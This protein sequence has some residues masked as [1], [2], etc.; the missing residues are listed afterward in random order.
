VSNRFGCR[1]LCGLFL[2]SPAIFAQSAPLVQD[3]FVVPGNASNYGSTT[4]LNVGGPSASQ[5]LVQFDLTQLPAGT[6]ASGIAKATLVLFVNKLSAAGTVNF[7]VANGIWTESSANGASGTPVAAAAVASGVT[8]NNSSDYIAVDATAAVQAWLNGTTNSG[9]IITPNTGTGVNIFFDSKES[10]TTSHPAV[11]NVT[12][13]G[14]GGTTG[15]T[16]ATGPTGAGTAGATGQAGPTGATGP[17][18]T[19]GSSGATGT[20]G[21]T[22]AGSTGATGATGPT[23]TNG[24]NGAT[25]TTGPTGTNG[26]NGS[27]GSNGAT[28]PTGGFSGYTK[29]GTLTS[30]Q[31]L[32]TT[33]TGFYPVND[34]VTVTLPPATTAG[35]ALIF[36]DVTSI[37]SG[38]TI[39]A[40]SG[41][42]IINL[43]GGRNSSLTNAVETII[44]DGIH[45]W[46]VLNQ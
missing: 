8:I 13:V 7:S 1:F 26:S 29:L 23:G 42:T 46:F 17:T 44:S 4:T 45:H 21:A 32:S 18:G 27:A 15:A 14:S 3:S 9:F 28:G 19:N 34:G 41:D 11:L 16:G 31:T 10:T 24:S 20:T 36:V 12:L 22:G 25:G 40:G 37:S 33:S 5:A 6:T 35:Q 2:L 38:I 30:T 39:N 43:S